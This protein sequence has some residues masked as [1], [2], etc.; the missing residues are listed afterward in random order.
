MST[1]PFIDATYAADMLHMSRDAVL[2]LVSSGK[3]RP[4]GGRAPNYFF[5]TSDVVTLVAELGVQPESESPKRVK[6]ASARV[7]ARL[8]A[9]ARWSEVDEEDVREWAVRTDPARREAARKAALGAIRRLETVLAVLD[10][11]DSTMSGAG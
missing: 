4:Y 5:R 10:Q 7:Q 11:T 3:L 2:D 9:D 6:S 1:P 8:T